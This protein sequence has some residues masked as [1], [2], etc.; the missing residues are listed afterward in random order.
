VTSAVL[1]FNF[2]LWRYTK[3]L[4]YYKCL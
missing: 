1:L 3:I 4:Y 2:K